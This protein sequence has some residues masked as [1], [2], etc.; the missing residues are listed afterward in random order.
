M[1]KQEK[2]DLIRFCKAGYSLLQIRGLVSCCDATI[3]KYMKVFAP[4]SEATH[5]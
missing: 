1:T 3:R 5:D 4:K 2:Y